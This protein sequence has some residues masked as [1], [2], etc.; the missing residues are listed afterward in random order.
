MNFLA[1]LFLSP[2]YDE[3]M[4]GNFMADFVKGKKWQN[5]PPQIAKGVLLHRRIDS[6]MDTHNLILQGKKRLHNSFGKYAGVIIDIYYDYFLA[7][8]WEDYSTK[9]LAVFAEEVY[10]FL[11]KEKAIFP[12]KVQEILPYMIEQNWLLNYKDLEF[13]DKTFQRL[14]RRIKYSLPLKNAVSILNA[15]E[16]DLEKE[17]HLFLP[18]IINFSQEFLSKK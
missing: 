14:Q 2:N 6:F 8:N 10:I 1:H 13:L 11:D 15:Q 3:I 7:K 5:Y 18:Q 9:D 12:E 17:F 4:L 16:K